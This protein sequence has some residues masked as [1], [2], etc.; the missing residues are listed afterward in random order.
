MHENI[1]IIE[2]FKK[3][4]YPSSKLVLVIEVWWERYS[5]DEQIKVGEIE[6]WIELSLW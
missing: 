1:R 6:W 3:F 2:Q 4:T 5:E